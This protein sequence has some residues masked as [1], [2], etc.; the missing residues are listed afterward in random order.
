[1]PSFQKNYLLTLILAG[2][3]L[4]LVIKTPANAETS[5]GVTNVEVSV[6]PDSATMSSAGEQLFS[7]SVRGTSNVA[8]KWSTTAGSISED[9]LFR[10]PSVSNARNVTITAAS[11][12]H[13]RSKGTVNVLVVPSGSDATAPS[14]SAATDSYSGNSSQAYG[15]ALMA[16]SGAAVNNTANSTGAFSQNA[17][18]NVVTGATNGRPPALASLPL[19]AQL[20]DGPAGSG[21]QNPPQSAPGTFDGPAELPRIY[22]NSAMTDTPA[23]GRVVTLNAGG[24]LQSAL[25]NA[26]CG[27]TIML[28]A[29][30]TFSG[31]YTLPAKSCDDNHWI[32]VRTSASDSQLPAE[33]TRLTPC[34][35]GVSSLPGRPAFNCKSTAVVTAKIVGVLSEGPI[36]LAAGANHYRLVG[37][38]ITRVP[39]ERNLRIVY[40]LISAAQDGAADHII[41]DRVWM[42]G[43]A[44]D[45]TGHGI[46]LNGVTYAAVIDSFLTDFHCVSGIGSCT[47]AQ[48]ISGGNGPL[49]G[50]PYKI[51]NNFLE[52]SAQS[53]MFGG[54]KNV[55]A[56]PA[57][58]EI[59]R[60]HFFKPLIWKKGQPGFVGG[61]SGHPFI[62]KNLFELKN[63]ERVLFEG[64][65]LENNWGGFSQHGFGI[66]L[67]PRG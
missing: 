40:Q 25:N 29:G 26:H 58:M 15:S 48:A 43:T 56:V 6:S 52:A 12:N 66:L 55:S 44:Q 28:Q 5:A 21:T 30:A 18:A 63:A 1:M 57:D 45:E 9:G 49:P 31:T 46:R 54:G 37:L 16:S 24:D 3:T 10:A 32:I 53:V 14:T 67:T 41:L 65:I 8:V 35:S 4:I 20:T 59:R 39:A 23:P 34:Y 13:P 36:T 38:E 50:G 11:A 17:S 60:N 7:A 51:V 42:H 27:D 19:I 2:L 64:N 33:G 22:I 47:D 61:T 62:V